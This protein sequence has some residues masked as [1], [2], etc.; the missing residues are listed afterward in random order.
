MAIF[1][2]TGVFVAARNVREVDHVKARGLLEQALKGEFGT[3]YTSDYAVDEAVA[4]SYSHTRNF[5][6]ALG[7]GRLALGS[8]R[9]E[10]PFTGGAE[11]HDSWEKFRGLGKKP[12]SFTDCVSLVHMERRGIE[13]IMSFDSGFDG[14]ATR[15]H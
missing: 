1:V 14:L 3:V 9:V 6:L 12:L 13:R 11:F 2:D 10:K 8:P 15:I 4:T 5:G 7:V